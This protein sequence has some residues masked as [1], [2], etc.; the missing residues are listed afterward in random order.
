[1]SNARREAVPIKSFQVR[2]KNRR[3]RGG[4]MADGTI[5]FKF[6]RLTAHRSVQGQQIRLSREAVVAMI[7]IMAEIDSFVDMASRLHGVIDA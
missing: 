4:L 5:L 7:S 3:V 1:M 2:L 6:K